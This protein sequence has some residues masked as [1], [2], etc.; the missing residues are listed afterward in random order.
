MVTLRISRECLALAARRG[1]WRLCRLRQ[2]PALVTQTRRFSTEVDGG[3][4]YDLVVIGGGSGGLAASKEAAQFGKK[5]AVLDFVK[6]TPQGM[7]EFCLRVAVPKSSFS[8]MSSRL[9]CTWLFFRIPGYNI[10]SYCT[11]GSCCSHIAT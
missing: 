4:D 2:P 11:S 6:P 9:V 3:Y 8:G 10:Y 5:V 1:N 7:A